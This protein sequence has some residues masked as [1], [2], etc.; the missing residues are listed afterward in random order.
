MADNEKNIFAG[1]SQFLDASGE[2]FTYA[3]L[4]TYRN[5]AGELSEKEKEFFERHL[6]ACVSCSAR[7]REIAEVEGEV[8]TEQPK[9]ILNFSPSLFRYAIAA[10][11]IIA[12][13]IAVVVMQNPQQEQITTQQLPA[14]QNIAEAPLNPERFVPNQVLENFVERNVRSSSGITLTVPKTGDTLAF[15][16]TFKWE[17]NDAAKSIMITV[18]DNKNFEVW[19]ETSSLSELTSVKKLEPGL[20]YIKLQTDDKLVQMG[21]FVVVK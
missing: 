6:K 4:S 13:G 14:E 7:L 1:Y 18:V 9:N 2:H 20:Y 12:I 21:K 10:I 8:A 5:S 16:Y 19:K 15:P 11:L 3:A 17:G